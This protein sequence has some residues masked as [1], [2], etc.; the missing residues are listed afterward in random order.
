MTAIG[1]TV[2]LCAVFI[3]AVVG[4]FVYSTLRTPVLS[5]E[6][7]RE[8]GVF[9]L[10]RPR[11]I[12]EIDLQDHTGARFTKATLE[13]KWSF[14]FFGFT[15]C[16]DICPTSMSVLGQVALGLERNNNPNAN[17]FQ[18]ILVTVDPERDTA[19][20][21]GTYATAFSPSF[22]GVRGTRA[23]TAEFATQLNVAF[24][25]VPDGD[26]YTMDH[27]G[28]IVIVN[29]MGHYH[30]F[31]KLPHDPETISLSFQSLVAGF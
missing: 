2:A 17:Q 15:H 27:T 13:G 21:L 24:A 3:T 8:R 14:I 20:K 23:K 18:G 26:G 31:V 30:G 10:P 29:P 25:K 9:L 5:E 22:L 1:R 12:A 19:E 6:E 28:N 4:M 16:P 11:A 7:M